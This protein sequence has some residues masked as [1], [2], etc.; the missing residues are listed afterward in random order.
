[1]KELIDYNEF[2]SIE[3]KLDIRVGKIVD[4]EPVAKSNKLLKLTVDFGNEQRIVVTNIAPEL[5]GQEEAIHVLLYER[6][7]FIMNLKPVTMMGIESTA[8]IMVGKNKNG[9][10]EIG[11]SCSTGS[12]LM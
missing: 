7:P 9:D 2:L 4:V 5:G 11:R 6:C 3:K 1:M 8:M 10:L 12:K